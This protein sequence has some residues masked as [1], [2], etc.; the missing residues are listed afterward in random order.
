MGIAALL[1]MLVCSLAAV[2]FEQNADRPRVHQ[3]LT[4]RQ[5]D[6]GCSCDGSQ[7]CT[8]LPLVII[9]TGGQVIPG[10]PTS[11]SDRFD[12][13]IYTTAADGSNT[14]TVDVS[15]IDQTDSNN[16]PSDTP[17]FQTKST[18]R[19]RGNSSRRFDK[20]PYLLDFI[21]EDGEN[22][23]IAVMGMDAHHEWI[24]N[25]PYLDKTMVRN[26]MWYNIAGELMDYAPNVRFCELILDGEYQGLYL[27]VESITDG[28]DCRLD[29]SIDA[30][31][32][33][34][35][36]YLL[37]L[38]RPTETDLDDVR[39]IYS[40]LERTG[41]LKQDVSIRYPG[42]ANLT[43]EMA[44]RIE[45]DFAEFE[46]ALY[47]YDY[48]DHEYGYWEWIDVDSFVDYYLI[49]ELS[50]NVDAGNYSTYLYK[51]LGEK[52]KLCVWDFNNACDNYQE[53]E[54]SPYEFL[55]Y[56][57]PIYF[58]LF[59][60]EAFVE[61]VIARYQQLR[62]SFLSE[63]YLMNYI[64]QTIAYLGDAVDR[65]FAVWGYTFQDQTMLTP[66]DRNISS[67]D[68]AV[69]QLK[70]FLRQRGSWIDRNIDTLRQYSHPSRNKAY[71]Y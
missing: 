60:D 27:M 26:Y 13:T 57:R 16:H 8:H 33:R 63:E 14:I 68:S 7:L 56:D 9:E 47:S 55:L 32:K 70:D 5:P 71:E 19:I 69:E 10:E 29:L 12:H 15:V 4:A 62:Q 48:D 11:Q 21:G 22:R 2:A 23:D 36:G 1:L 54:T 39:N 67:F 51:S 52:Y 40:L 34:I 6:A 31:N 25:G 3:H 41:Q 28:Q 53:M 38:D 61:K 17:A 44:G 49:N 45:R 24:L 43:E 35:T 20:K 66:A 37:R 50:A 65:N 18:F 42:R 30:Q 59:K 46:K 58:M 64:D